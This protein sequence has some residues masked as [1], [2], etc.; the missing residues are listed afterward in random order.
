[1][2]MDILDMTKSQ[3]PFGV[4]HKSYGRFGQDQMSCRAS[5]WQTFGC[6]G[7]DQT[8][9]K[10][11]GKLVPLL[12]CLKGGFGDAWL[13]LIPFHPWLQPQETASWSVNTVFLTGMPWGEHSPSGTGAHPWASSLKVPILSPP[14]RMNNDHTLGSHGLQCYL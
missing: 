4:D 7:Q 11:S 2:F 6:F 13:N 1:M 12:Q 9:G 14:G 3:G 8:T 5:G 10:T